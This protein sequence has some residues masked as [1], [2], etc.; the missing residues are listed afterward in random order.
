[1]REELYF[2]VKSVLLLLP[3][4]SNLI[5]KKSHTILRASTLLSHFSSCI[6]F[7]RTVSYRRRKQRSIHNLKLFCKKDGIISLCLH[8]FGL[9]QFVHHPSLEYT[10]YI[11]NLW[12]G[13]CVTQQSRSKA[14]LYEQNITSPHVITYVY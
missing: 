4:N 2:E 10:T 6:S 11:W 3:V 5:E 14:T 13:Q 8:Q 1:M 7:M 12:K 9:S